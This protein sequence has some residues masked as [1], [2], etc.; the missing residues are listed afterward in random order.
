M[1]R[2]LGDDPPWIARLGL[3]GAGVAM[4]ATG[5]LILATLQVHTPYALVGLSIVLLVAGTFLTTFAWVD[6]EV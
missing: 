4:M 6:I 1:I 5:I 2:F 3:S